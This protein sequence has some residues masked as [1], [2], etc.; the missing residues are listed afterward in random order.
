[1]K[2]NTTG[3]L[4]TRMIM[5]LK[6]LWQHIVETL[7]NQLE[8]VSRMADLPLKVDYQN[9]VSKISIFGLLK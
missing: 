2:G 3:C 4:K 1:M 5:K 8:S 6:A 9:A 7:L